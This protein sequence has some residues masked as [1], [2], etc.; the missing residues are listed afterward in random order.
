MD[1]RHPIRPLLAYAIGFAILFGAAAFAGELAPQASESGGITIAVKPVD[2]AA[3]AARW[4]FRV[5]VS[6]GGQRVTD[7]LLRSAYLLNRAAD[8]HEAPIGWKGD[9]AGRARRTGVLSFK[10]VK[11]TP[12]AIELRIE[13]P[14]ERA[15]R[16]F[17]WDLDCPCN[18]P[19]M[20]AS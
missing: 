17:R 20:H 4:S 2:V 3:K 1:S 7:D 18:D 9:L 16:V 13:R 14:G 5:S 19:S 6:A 12:T 15:P 8:R 11:P 10:A